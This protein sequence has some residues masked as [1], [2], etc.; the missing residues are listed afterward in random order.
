MSQ[1]GKDYFA[2][3]Y[4]SPPFSSPWIYFMVILQTILHFVIFEVYDYEISIPLV[5]PIENIK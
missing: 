4:L 3:P 2:L 5:A 1:L